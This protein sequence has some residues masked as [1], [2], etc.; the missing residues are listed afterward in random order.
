ME[1]SPNDLDAIC[2]YLPLYFTRKLIFV[3]ILLLNRVGQELEKA[4]VYKEAAGSFSTMIGICEKSHD[5]P[6]KD[7]ATVF[8][9]F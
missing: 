3:T 4:G 1:T 7:E 5:V 9:L 8:F 6:R 2:Q